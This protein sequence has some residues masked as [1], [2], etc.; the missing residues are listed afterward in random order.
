M[1]LFLFS[2]RPLG[3]PVGDA[4]WEF[5]DQVDEYGLKLWWII[6][7]ETGVDQSDTSVNATQA[8]QNHGTVSAFGEY[9]RVPTPASTRGSKRPSHLKRRHHDTDKIDMSPV[10]KPDTDSVKNTP[11]K[12]ANIAVPPRPR[13]AARKAMTWTKEL[14]EWGEVHCPTVDTV[15][16]LIDARVRFD[17]DQKIRGIPSIDS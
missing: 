6:E 10:K 17:N 13:R 9:T 15:A 3:F 8:L 11:R 12:L 7:Q 4:S 2:F 14:I 1:P 16:N 5:S